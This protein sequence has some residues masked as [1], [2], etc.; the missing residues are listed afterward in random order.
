MIT[1]ANAD[2]MPA[3][4]SPPPVAAFTIAAPGPIRTRKNVPIASAVALRQ[5]ACARYFAPAAG[6]EPAPMWIE[7]SRARS[8]VTIVAGSGA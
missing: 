4:P 8:C 3:T 6:V 1:N 5:M 7:S 2:A